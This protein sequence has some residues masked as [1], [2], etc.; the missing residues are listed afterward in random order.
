MSTSKQFG[1]P[2]GLPPFRTELENQGHVRVGDHTGAVAIELAHETPLIGCE[3]GP[4]TCGPPHFLTP[5][6]NGDSTGG[7]K[8]TPGLS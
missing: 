3:G 6:G 2:D 4:S 1:I 8:L 7:L 5:K